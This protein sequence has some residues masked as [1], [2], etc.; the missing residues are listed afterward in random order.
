MLPPQIYPG[1]NRQ[2]CAVCQQD[3][4]LHMGFY[5]TLSCCSKVGCRLVERWFC[6]DC[7]DD[8]LDSFQREQGRPPHGTAEFH[9]WLYHDTVCH[10]CGMDFNT[11]PGNREVIFNL[12]SC[13]GN[14]EGCVWYVF[15]FIACSCVQM[16][17]AWQ[18]APDW[19]LIMIPSNAEENKK[20]LH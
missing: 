2:S 14:R 12:C 4:P 17:V 7:Y 8:R 16:L 19:D 10:W 6:H 9:V 13:P 11:C 5:T 20:S 1:H 15:K 3:M 18:L